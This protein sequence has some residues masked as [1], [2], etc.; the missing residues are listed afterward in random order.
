MNIPLW[1]NGLMD[2]YLS[3]L[4][5]NNL[6]PSDMPP[7]ASF[8]VYGT[9]ETELKLSSSCHIL[10]SVDV[11][12]WTSF[13]K[14]QEITESEKVLGTVYWFIVGDNDNQEYFAVISDF[15]GVVK[16]YSKKLGNSE[17]FKPF[18]VQDQ[19]PDF[20]QRCHIVYH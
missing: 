1:I 3:G 15:Q 19:L 20:N 6:N 18:E 14:N 10:E 17:P 4:E 9:E 7:Q 12:Q 8:I 2:I 13:M 16:G 11:C 5:D